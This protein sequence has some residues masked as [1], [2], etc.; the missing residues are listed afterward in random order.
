MM[1]DTFGGL[2]SALVDSLKTSG[3]LDTLKVRALFFLCVPHLLL[4]SSWLSRATRP[5]Q[6]YPTPASL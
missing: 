4:S 5:C 3:K 6:P 1:V 2:R